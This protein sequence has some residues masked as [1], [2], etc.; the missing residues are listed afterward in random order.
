MLLQDLEDK[1][2]EY[3][4]FNF[5]SRVQP[6]SMKKMKVNIAKFLESF[7]EKMEVSLGKLK[8][9]GEEFEKVVG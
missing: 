3:V 6:L 1:Y 8:Q 9:V 7:N 5:K 2:F 4:S